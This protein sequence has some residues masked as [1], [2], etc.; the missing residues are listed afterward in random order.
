MIAIEVGT[1]PSLVTVCK[2]IFLTVNNTGKNPF[3]LYEM[4]DFNDI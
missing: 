2:N 4:P 1:N 3:F